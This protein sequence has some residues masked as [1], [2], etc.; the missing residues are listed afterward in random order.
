[1]RD[2]A[3]TL[4]RKALVKEPEG[5][6]HPE[7]LVKT[8]GP[9]CSTKPHHTFSTFLERASP[10]VGCQ[11]LSLAFPSSALPAGNTGLMNT[12][13]LHAT[14]THP[15]QSPPPPPPPHHHHF[16]G[17]QEGGGVFL[18]KL[19]LFILFATDREPRPFLKTP[20]AAQ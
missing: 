12:S 15:S 2:A 16:L 20:L 13:V 14:G 9:F 7:L 8:P 10:A 4:P 6:S 11:T 1:M 3:C 18:R 17:S 5:A 19:Y